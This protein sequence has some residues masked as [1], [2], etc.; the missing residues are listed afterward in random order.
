MRLFP[1]ILIVASVVGCGGDDTSQP[2]PEPE[3]EVAWPNLE[4][5]PLVPSY[6]G[7]PFP[8]NVF[9]VPDA[10][11]E[12]GRRVNLLDATLP[13]ADNGATSSLQGLLPSDGFSTGIALLTELPGATLEGMPSLTDIDAS[14]AN[15]AP[16]VVLDAETGER[17]PHFVELDVSNPTFEERVFMIRPVERLKDGTRYIVAIRGVQGPD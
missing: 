2:V 7:Y 4:C 9:T 3:P 10:D 12:T 16:T 13:V 6:C 5:D 14:L 15:D 8:N 1:A 17:V 11:S